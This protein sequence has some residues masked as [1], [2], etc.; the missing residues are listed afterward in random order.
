MEIIRANFI[1]VFN[2]IFSTNVQK[3]FKDLSSYSVF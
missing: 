2:Y 3:V 1:S